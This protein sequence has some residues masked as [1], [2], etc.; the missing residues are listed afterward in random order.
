[1]FN[2]NQLVEIIWTSKTKTYF[3]ELGYEYTKIGDKFYVKAKDLPNGSKK[4]VSVVCDCCGKEYSISYYNYTKRPDKPIYVCR[5]CKMKMVRGEMSRGLAK[6]KFKQLK[7]ICYEKGYILLTDVSE[8]TGIHMQ[9]S[10][11]CSK[12]GLQT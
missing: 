2:E 9:I 7:K 4:K 3:I 6:D 1:M 11:V 10:Y 5:S 8:Y 12:H